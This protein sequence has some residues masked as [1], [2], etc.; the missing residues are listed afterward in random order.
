MD[1]NQF[2]PTPPMGWNSW[3]CYA[4]AVTEEQ[5]LGNARYM[6]DNLKPYGWTYIVCDIQWSE[7]NAGTTDREYIPF[8]RLTLDEYSRQIPAPNRFPSSANGAG[9]KPVADKIHAMG[10]KF[11]VH[12]M[13]GIPRQAVHARM[14]I[15]GTGRTADEIANP[16]SICKWNSDMYGIDAA[17]PDAQ[18]YYDSIFALYA[19]WGVDYIKVDD[20][21]NTNMYPHAPYSAEKEVEMIAAAIARCGRPMV[22][23]LSPGPA[24]IDKAWHLEKYANMWRITDDFWDRWDL[25]KNMFD[26]CEVWQ[27]HVSPGCWPDCDMLPL[28]HIGMG[29]HNGRKTAFTRDEQ[30]TMMTL[31]C[32][33]RSPLMMGGELRDNDDWTLSLLTH[34]EV[35]RLIGHSSGAR[36]LERS[37]SH[38]IW[39]SRDDDGSTYIALFNL[40]D[41][42]IEVGIS[43]KEYGLDKAFIRNVWE[44]RELGPVLE[45]VAAALAPHGAALYRIHD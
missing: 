5:L 4:A 19:D 16:S 35:L 1:K 29:F 6:A 15:F 24:V 30:L 42:P 7:P 20:I 38:A 36:Q 13:R 31:W 32:I 39:Q 37:E 11:G 23:S 25:L 17:R 12:I 10:L 41:A 3:D 27:R 26:R 2:A 28:G 21:C 44:R 18:A 33:F 8:A 40:G 34:E 43:S 9:F 14:P 22:L 45:R